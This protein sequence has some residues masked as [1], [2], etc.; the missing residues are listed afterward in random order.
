[1]PVNSA[2]QGIPEQ[3]GADPANLP[4]AQV[5]WDG[6][7]ENRLFQRYTNLADRTA[8]NPAP[9]ENEVSALAA[10]DRVD[11]FDSANWVSLHQR[12]FF[13]TARVAVGADQTLAP[14]SIA[15]QSITAL[16][17]ALPTA[18]TFGWRATVFA[19]AAAAADI[20]FAYLV[21]AGITMLWGGYGGATTIAAGIGDG[22][23]G[24]CQTASDAFIAFGTSGTGTA[25]T[26]MYIH[27]GEITMGGT[28]GNLQMRG[29]QNTSDPSA[30]VIRARSRLQVWR[31]L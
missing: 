2:N 19:D 30:I 23:W 14:S 24:P 25:N 8:R 22:V 16:V 7:M 1:M 28:A 4:A 9:N 5:S 11:I 20:R 17:V 15:L 6:V 27:E 10:E 18:G 12:S 13:A 31:I 21:P 29:C 26:Q 3:Q